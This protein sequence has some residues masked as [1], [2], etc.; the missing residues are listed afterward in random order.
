MQREVEDTAAV[1]ML[2]PGE[3]TLNYPHWQLAIPGGMLIALVAVL[4]VFVS[5]FAVGGGFFLVLTERLARQQKDASLLAYCRRHSRFFALLT[6]VFGAISGVGIWFTIGLVS[7]GGDIVAD[8][9]LCVG[10]GDRVGLLF[11]RDC[12]GN[13][14][15]QNLG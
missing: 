5:H 1:I 9:H 7:P 10:M 11:R 3:S 2:W 8:S 12:R 13:H 4:H 6:L 15:L 14:L